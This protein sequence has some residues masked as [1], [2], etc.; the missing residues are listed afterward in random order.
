MPAVSWFQLTLIYLVGS[1]SFLLFSDLFI[2]ISMKFFRIWSAECL[3]YFRGRLS[4]DIAPIHRSFSYDPGVLVL[5][6][7]R[8]GADEAERKANTARIQIYLTRQHARNLM[9]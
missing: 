9:R 2:A 3:F 6:I 1:L 4:R 5:R 8:Q 7:Y